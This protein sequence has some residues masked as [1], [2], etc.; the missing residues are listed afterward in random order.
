M[1]HLIAHRGYWLSPSE[2]NT[3]TAFSRAL[4]HGFGIE[5]DFRDHDGHLVVSHDIPHAGVMTANEFSDLYQSCPV[6]APIALN[7]KSDGLQDLVG[8][9]IIRTTFQNAFVFDMAVPDMRSYI[10]KGIVT[11]TR[12]SE[13]E[14][15]PVLL[16]SCQGVWL[17]TFNN[18]WYDLSLVQ[19]ILGKGK[20]V[21]IVSP[22]LH[23]RPYQDLWRWLKES[24]LY[25]NS[26]VSLCTDLP[27]QAKEFFD[28]KN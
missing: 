18:I 4:A 24:N 3:A 5:T 13:H 22:E 7:I 17:D 19:M 20:S 23:G 27:L 11:Y 25:Q 1:L 16:E 6:A 9:L 15:V 26:L 28:V 2:K 10:Q 14:T 12:L 8:N 21:A